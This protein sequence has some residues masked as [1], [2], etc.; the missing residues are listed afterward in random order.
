M[1]CFGVCD[2]ISSLAF[3]EI[4][5]IVGRVPIFTL[6]AAINLA[7]IATMFIWKPTPSEPA[8]FYVLAGLWGVSD[9]VWQTQINGKLLASA[10]SKV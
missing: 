9:A 3:G 10:S 5:K 7:L 1:I 6:G 4:I 2:A 8:V